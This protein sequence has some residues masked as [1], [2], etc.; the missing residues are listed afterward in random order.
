MYKGTELKHSVRFNTITTVQ[1]T[2]GFNVVEQKQN[3]NIQSTLQQNQD[4]SIHPRGCSASIL[5][6]E[7]FLIRITQTIVSLSKRIP[8]VSRLEC[9]SLTE[10]KHS[11]R[12]NAMQF[13]QS[14]ADG[15][16]SLCGRIQYCRA[17]TELKHSVHFTTESGLQ[18]PSQRM[19]SINP[20]PGNISDQ[21]NTNNCILVQKNSN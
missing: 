16:E 19:F 6:Q 18:H 9:K 13:A 2:D 21:D 12:F 4:Y 17:K 3:S 14:L 11:V 10:L 7:T 20:C 5:V 1:F 8:T 15:S